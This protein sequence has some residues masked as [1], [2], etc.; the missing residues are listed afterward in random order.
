M[1]DL[2]KFTWKIQASFNIPEIQSQAS[3]DQGYSAPPAPRS[4][5]RGAFLPKRLEYQ[6][7]QQR[8]I[9][10][11]KAYC[12]CLQHW[13]EKSYLPISP[14]AHPLAESVRELC[15]AIGEFVTITKWDVL[16]GLEMARSRDSCQPSSMTLFSQVLGPLTKGQETPLAAIETAWQSGMLRLQGRA[17]SFLHPAPTWQPTHPPTVPTVPTFP[18]TRAL[19]VVQPITPPQLN[20]GASADMA[21]VEG[22]MLRVSSMST[23]TVVWDNS[24]GSVYLDTIAAS[25]GRM[26]LGSMEPN[27]GPTIEDIMD[28]S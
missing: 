13:A 12:Q 18:S 27:E 6:D 24:T 23:S 19:A 11:T 3:P 10:L 4:L 5:K 16:E 7:V 21:A 28:Q 2:H 15:L 1:A 17:H 8:P 26:V 22:V 25:I 20:W 9:L 14:G